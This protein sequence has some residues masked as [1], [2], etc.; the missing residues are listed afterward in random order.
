MVTGTGPG[1]AN[2]V[3]VTA[4][5][6]RNRQGNLGVLPAGMAFDDGRVLRD[7]EI[8]DV[9]EEVDVFAACGLPYLAPHLRT[10]ETYQRWAKRARPAGWL[11]WPPG[12]Y[13]H[14]LSDA[15]LGYRYHK[16]IVPSLGTRAEPVIEL[17]QEA[18]L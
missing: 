18:M 7:G 12:D 1:D 6:R 11:G 2:Q 17:R 14:M 10:V 3:L 5:G 4:A 9:P 15:K 8:L 16:L 13:V